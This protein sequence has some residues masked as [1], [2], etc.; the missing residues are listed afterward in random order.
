M[1]EQKDFQITKI[2]SSDGA[3]LQIETHASIPSASSL[4]KSYADIGYPDRYMVFSTVQTEYGVFG[5]KLSDGQTAKGLFLSCI[6][7][8]SMFPSQA[9]LLRALSAVSM[10][11]ALEEHTSKKLGIGWVSDIF[12]EKSKIGTV[13]LEGKLDNYTSYE[14]I[15]I[16]FKMKL[17]PEIFPPRLRDMV[18][19]VF[20]NDS[21]STEFIIAQNILSK[22]FPLYFSL[23]NKSKFMDTY[24]QK[25]SM[26]GQKAKYIDGAKRCSCKI[27][28]VN[29]ENG[30]LVV[31]V[32]NGKVIDVSSPSSV[33]LPKRVK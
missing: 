27:L 8:P 25:F 23:K 3:I 19:S 5:E 31:Q 1:P 30:A 18:K 16:S 32:K 28:N 22:F 26:R 6:L 20:E 10:L 24:K 13:T 12:C 14:Y 17:P 9:G 29:T 11:T 33:I 4:A 21:S 15:I 7:R 2:R